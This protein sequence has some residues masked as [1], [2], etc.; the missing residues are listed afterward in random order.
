MPADNPNRRREKPLRDYG[1]TATA[2]QMNTLQYY[3]ELTLLYDSR[4]QYLELEKEYH[5]VMAALFK[6]TL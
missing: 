3:M 4:D 5:K 2:G 6:H 1:R